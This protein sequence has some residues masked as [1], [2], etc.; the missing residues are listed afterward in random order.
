MVNETGFPINN[1]T[2][3]ATFGDGRGF[4]N[5]GV[6]WV[7]VEVDPTSRYIWKFIPMIVRANSPDQ[8]ARRL[9]T[10]RRNMLSTA[11]PRSMLDQETSAPNMVPV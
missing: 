11:H 5:Y 8:S 6:N 10:Q 3:V 1:F 4:A 9:L 7:K 2:R